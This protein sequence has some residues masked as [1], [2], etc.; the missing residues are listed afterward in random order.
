MGKGILSEEEPRGY[1]CGPSTSPPCS[2]RLAHSEQGRNFPLRH[3]MMT[4]PAP[5]HLIGWVAVSCA[6]I[7]VCTDETI[8]LDSKV[9]D[10]ARGR[11][12]YVTNGAGKALGIHGNRRRWSSTIIIDIYI[13]G[14]DDG[15]KALFSFQRRGRCQGLFHV[16]VKV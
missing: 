4:A 9:V 14:E 6:L 10:A 16:T 13:R 1:W 11:A 8:S 2:M 7:V 3:I 5:G 12:Y 15:N